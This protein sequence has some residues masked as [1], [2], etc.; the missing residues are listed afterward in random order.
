MPGLLTYLLL[1]K[2][3]PPHPSTQSWASNKVQVKICLLLEALPDFL[4][5]LNTFLS[6]FERK[7]RTNH[8]LLYF[9]ITSVIL[10]FHPLISGSILPFCTPTSARP[11]VPFELVLNPF[12]EDSLSFKI[13]HEYHPKT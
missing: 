7:V 3:S 9:T 4:L 10:L 6:V 8:S 13:F 1:F 5:V 12:G 11:H 2:M